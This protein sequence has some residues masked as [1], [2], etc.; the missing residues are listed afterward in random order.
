MTRLIE[1][2]TLVAEIAELYP[3][4]VN[5]LVY[6]YGFHCVGCFASQFE[7]LEEGAGVH[8]IYGKDFEELLYKVNE[9]AKEESNSKD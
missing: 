5:M 6:E 3:E 1:S 2:D 9:L 8:G 4:A 7:T